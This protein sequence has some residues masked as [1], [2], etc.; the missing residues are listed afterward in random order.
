M[1]D[2]KEKKIVLLDNLY[3]RVRA[4]IY[5]NMRRQNDV[6]QQIMIINLMTTRWYVYVYI[7][8]KEIIYLL[9]A[10]F[11]TKKNLPS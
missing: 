9:F 6:E 11:F 7:I 8:K 4:H 5:H 3:T 10:S 1:Y 2:V